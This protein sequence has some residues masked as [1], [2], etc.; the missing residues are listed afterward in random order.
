ML[1]WYQKGI[2]MIWQKKKSLWTQTRCEKQDGRVVLATF[3]TLGIIGAV[4]SI[5]TSQL[6]GPGFIPEL[7]LLS[8]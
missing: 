8:E 1:D 2:C 7:R 3:M 4:S 5:A 6:Q